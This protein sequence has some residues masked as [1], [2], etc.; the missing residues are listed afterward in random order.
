MRALVGIDGSEL[1]RHTAR[2]ARAVLRDD[3]RMTL[4]TVVKPLPPTGLVD[5]DISPMGV[6]TDELREEQL[7]KLVNDARAELHAFSHEL[8]LDD[9]EVVVV[10]GDPGPTLCDVAREGGY[11]LIVVG[12]HGTRVL[13][14]AL[15]GS[16]SQ[17]VLHHADCLV[18]VVREDG[19]PH[20][21]G[22]LLHRSRGAKPPAP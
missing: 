13:R 21:S 11:D 4:I 5:A 14:Q 22:G 10:P 6:Y 16:V 15:L 9:A 19:K 12:S 8:E 17:H 18:L 3:A 7:A 1:S 2:R 20:R